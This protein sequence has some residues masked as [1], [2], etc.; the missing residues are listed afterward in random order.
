MKDPLKTVKSMD[1][2]NTFTNMV[3]D[4]KVNIKTD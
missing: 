3:G 4:M 2:V 1:M